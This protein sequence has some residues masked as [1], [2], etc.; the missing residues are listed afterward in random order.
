MQKFARRL[1]S[2]SEG[3][4]VVK[5]MMKPK[6]TLQKIVETIKFKITAEFKEFM[7]KM[8]TDK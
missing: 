6:K 8:A 5:L 4:E 2:I 7:V 3:S 1:S